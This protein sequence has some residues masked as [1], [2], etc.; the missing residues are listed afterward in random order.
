MRGLDTDHHAL[1]SM[2]RIA[3]YVEDMTE[4]LSDAVWRSDTSA[5]LPVSWAAPLAEAGRLTSRSIEAW[6]AG[7]SSMREAETAVEALMQ[8]IHGSAAG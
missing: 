3:F 4:V 2:E 1:Q 6:D 5:P 7:D 8:R